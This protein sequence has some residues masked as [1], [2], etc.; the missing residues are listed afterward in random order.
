MQLTS[1]GQITVP[2]R[3]RKKHGFSKG[4]ELEF[5]DTKDGVKLVK[6]YSQS[7]V[8]KVFGILSRGKRRGGLSTDRIMKKLRPR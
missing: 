7:P 6:A 2:I 5:I 3:L 1:K 4:T 8:D